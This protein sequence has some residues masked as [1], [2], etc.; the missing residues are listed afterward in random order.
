MK[1]HHC[2]RIEFLSSGEQESW[3]LARLSNNISE[4]TCSVGELGLIPGLG[5]S[6]GGRPRILVS[7]MAQ[8]QLFRVHL[9]CGRTGFNPWVGKTPWRKAW[10]PTSVF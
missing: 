7:F 1:P 8:Q 4:S 9:Q 5:S 10:Q 6:P 3:C 2:P